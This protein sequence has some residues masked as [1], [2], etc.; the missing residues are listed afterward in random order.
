MVKP[1]ASSTPKIVHLSPR[2]P[3]G[4][5]KSLDAVQ[6]PINKF[7]LSPESS[8]RFPLIQGHSERDKSESSDE[9]ES[10]DCVDSNEEGECSSMEERATNTIFCN[11]VNASYVVFFV[12]I[13]F[14]AGILYG[15]P[16]E[17]DV[18]I[19]DLK[20]EFPSQV[21]DFWIYIGEALPVML[22]VA[23]LRDTSILN[24]YGEVISRNKAK[25]EKNGVM[26]IKNLEKVPGVSAQAFHS[27]C[28]E[29]NPVV[30]EALFIF[31]MKVDEY[32]E[33]ELKFVE[34]YLHSRWSD[35]K[36]DT[37]YALFTRIA[38]IVLPIKVER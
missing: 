5:N 14:G 16:D 8:R 38:N 30:N 4:G 12:A 32:H 25:L 27:L 17:Q 3:I 18:T 36:E 11:C 22:E 34:E 28:D 29:F 31:T 6:S 23:D 19:T 7:T 1:T 15:Y 21:D 9:K 37:F 2:P 33:N 26:I 13:L 24:D 20:S 10:D 35:I